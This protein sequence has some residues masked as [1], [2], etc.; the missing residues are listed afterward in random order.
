MCLPVWPCGLPR[1][2]RC[3]CGCLLV[4]D[5]MRL[6]NT[7]RMNT[8]GTAPGNWRW[9]IGDSGVWARLAKESADLKAVAHASNRLAKPPKKAL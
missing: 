9:R 1:L 7:A 5:V 2:M 6:D 4:Q 8:P 3:V